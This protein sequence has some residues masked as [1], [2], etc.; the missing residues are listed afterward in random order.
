MNNAEKNR[1]LK[2][3]Q[4]FADENIILKNGQMFIELKQLEEKF[5][6]ECKKIR[7]TSHITYRGI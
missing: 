4:H 2:C 5:P 7:E 6:E 1:Y 3:I